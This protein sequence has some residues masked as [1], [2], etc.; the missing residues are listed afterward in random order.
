MKRLCLT[1]ALVPGC[2]QAS[3]R[4]ISALTFIMADF[5][6]VVG[7]SRVSVYVIVPA[8]GDTHTF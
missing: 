3:S 6:M 7:G 2:A 1:P 8:G 5:V 4:Q